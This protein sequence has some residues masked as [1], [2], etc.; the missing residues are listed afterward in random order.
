MPPPDSLEQT[1]LKLRERIAVLERANTTLGADR[2]R[3]LK[4]FSEIEEML[5]GLG[6]LSLAG[7]VAARLARAERRSAKVDE[8]LRTKVMR[9]D[10][11][12]YMLDFKRDTGAISD[13]VF[14]ELM[15]AR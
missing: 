12:L 7:A 5:G 10:E 4:Q 6:G 2:S 11:R 3:L 14:A 15:S 8:K 13:D 1:I 9:R